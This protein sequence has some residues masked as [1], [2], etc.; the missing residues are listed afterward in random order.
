MST[1]YDLCIIG[2]GSGNSIIDSR[3]DDWSIAMVERSVF[4]GTCLNRGCIPSK[5]LIYPADVIESVRQAT[6]LGVKASIDNVDWPSIRDRT[7]GRIDPI[8]E[9]GRQYRH[10]L[11][12]VAVFEEDARFVGPFELQVGERTLTADRFVLAA[13]ARSFLPEVAGLVE[14]E[15]YTSDTIMRVESAPEHLVILGGGFI[16]AEMAHVFEAFGSKVTILLRRDQICASHDPLVATKLTAAFEKRFTIVPN[17]VVERVDRSGAETTLHV[18]HSGEQVRI[19][20]DALLVAAGRTP[21][22]DQLNVDAT[23]VK[24]DPHGYVVVDEFQQ[25]TVKGIWALGDISN[26]KQ[27]KHLAN[28]EAKVVQHNLVNAEPMAVDERVV[29]YAVFTQPQVGGVGMSEQEAIAAGVDFIAAELEFGAT[30]YGWAMEDTTSAA[31]VL[32]DPQ[33][34]LILGADV[35]GPQASLLVQP[36]VQAMQFGQTVDQVARDVIYPHPA[37]SEVVENLL[38]R[39]I[40]V[41]D[42][43]E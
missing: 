42:A 31:K 38:L 2:S 18:L 37:L 7:F 5:M 4:G 9:G 8:A 28:R 26:P 43:I 11:P 27:L 1:H 3:M 16:A 35:V 21:N 32:V 22:G 6:K 41:L 39:A 24:L 36:L 13:G 15:P 10:S 17:S 25:T 40:E 14:S 34:R 20:C 30:A 12:N 33:T 23:G 29:P 19:T